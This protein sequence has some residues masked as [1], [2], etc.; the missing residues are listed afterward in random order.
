MSLALTRA[1]IIG[2]AP[3]AAAV[4]ASQKLAHP[5]QWRS[6][7]RSA[8]AVWGE[9][10]GSALYRT[11]IALAELAVQCSCPSRKFPCKH[12]LGLLLMAAEGFERIPELPEPEWVQSWQLARHSA[13]TG[14]A[15]RVRD[16]A[17][18]PVDAA[19]QAKRAERR[20]ENILAGLDQLDVWLND[21]VRQGLARVQGE[22]WAFWDAQARRLV[23]AQ[24]PGLAS[25]VRALGERVGSHDNWPER[26]LD[27]LGQLALLSHAYRRLDRL[28]PPLAADV[29]RLV[30]ITL[31]QSEVLAHG[32]TLE[33]EWHVLCDMI[34]DG[35]R[36]RT[37]RAWLRGATS[38]QTALVLQ[39]TPLGTRFESALVT[40]TKLP[41]RLAYWPSAAPQRA[42]IVER[43]APASPLGAAPAGSDVE[44]A[45]AGY[46]DLLAKCP[47]LGASL[48][49]LADVVPLPAAGPEPYALVDASGA[50]LPLRGSAHDVLLALSGGHPLT[51]AGEWDGYAF[52]PRT[53]WA[54]D[55][56]V[57]LWPG[58]GDE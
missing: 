28:A 31:D 54:E 4:G 15:M 39:F 17:K 12:A 1:Q 44:S 49:V 6:L 40:G 37:Q 19:A 35:E 38:G 27:D 36:V 7:G 23:D 41:A 14:K 22:S 58:G 20:H 46:A 13:T 30:G 42:L 25:R 16:K 45:L 52:S 32:A 43:T 9:C 53:V 18:K 10:Q 34:D 8:G 3:D 26:L 24:A 48:L 51:L 33:D 55:R 21:L 5:A 2:L 47:W 56:R 50:A 29:R 11:Q 57:S